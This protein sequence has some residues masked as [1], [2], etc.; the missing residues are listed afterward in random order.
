MWHFTPYAYAYLVTGGVSLSMALICWRRRAIP[1]GTVLAL[2]MLA[3]AAW[4]IFG[5]LEM[6]AVGIP[7]KV[8]WSKVAYLGTTPSP[9]LLLIFA[10]TYSQQHRWLTRRNILALFVLPVLTILLA[11]TNEWHHLVWTSFTP[12]PSGDNVLIYGHGVGFWVLVAYSYL[13]LTAGIL[14]LAHA[15]I[16]FRGPYRQQALLLLVGALLPSVWNVIY[17][18]DVSPLPGLDATPIAFA[19]TG[20]ILA[21]GIFRFRL[22]DLVPVVRD[23]LI[24]NMRDGVL[25]LDAQNRIVDINPAARALIGNDQALIGQDV[26]QVCAGIARHLSD[27]ETPAEIVLGDNPLRYLDMR[28]SALPDPQAHLAGRLIVLHDIGD[29][30]KM[31]AAIREMNATLEHLVAERTEELQATVHRLQDEIAERKQAEE[32]LRQMDEALAQHV[33][34]QSHK[35]AALYEVILFAGQAL[36]VPEI[37]ARVLETIMSTMDCEAGCVHQWDECTATLR[38]SAQ[39]GLSVE[40]QSQIETIPASWLLDDKIP[41][42]ITNLSAAPDIPTAIC[43]PGLE[44]YLGIP[45]FLQ[46]KPTGI[47]SAFWNHTRYFSVEDIALFSA[48]ADQLGIIV[49]NTRLRERSEAAAIQQERR[50]LGRDLHDSVTQ[51]LHS[52][53][54]AAD[55]AHN[56]LRQGKFDLLGASLT[57]LA[58]SARQALKEM[59]LLLY[60]LRLTTLEQ[61]NLVEALQTRL[62]AVERR[63]GIDA[64]LIVEPLPYLPKTWEGE[65]YCVAM[66]ALNNSL[67]YAR[68]TRVTVNLCGHAHGIELEIADDG[69]GIDPQ[70]RKPGG[71]GLQSMAERADRLGGKLTIQS[72][73]GQG[74]RVHLRVEEAN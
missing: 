57:Q 56:R 24:E 4:A 53:A 54:L 10:L 8:F 47:L 16:R 35:L 43:L 63:A 28:V 51:S 23:R 65:L 26:S 14:A 25:V 48:L 68:A 22:L 7:A 39:R 61:V 30:K 73:P 1:G 41:R 31:E 58:E 44:V 64:Q 74:T 34:N 71:M 17:V 70:A 69:K 49:E 18:F 40:M 13:A 55:I 19:F 66:E 36:A 3:V 60:E 45:T 72:A 67:K 37:Q 6:A 32:K 59:R 9:A 15:F 29:R 52:L 21:L 27:D 50:R 38:L 46:G 20:W 33:A 62:D 11:A 5:A 42:A 2:L 12:S